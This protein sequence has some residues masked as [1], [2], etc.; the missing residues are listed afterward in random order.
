MCGVV[1]HRDDRGGADAV[2]VSSI[3]KAGPKAVLTVSMTTI[4]R[5]RWCWRAGSTLHTLSGHTAEIVSLSFNQS[6]NSIITGSFDHTVKVWD[7]RSGEWQALQHQHA[8]SR[9]P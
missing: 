8:S 5:H 7:T 9:R 3:T 2:H 4:H 1:A 6:G